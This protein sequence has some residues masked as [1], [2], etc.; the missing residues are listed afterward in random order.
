MT[1]IVGVYK[2]IP[3]LSI[4]EAASRPCLAASS[5]DKSPSTTL[6]IVSWI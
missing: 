2:S 3:Y 5:M 1:N 6:R 4:A